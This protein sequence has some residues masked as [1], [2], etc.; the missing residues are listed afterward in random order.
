MNPL[1]GVVIEEGQTLEL[2]VS[3]KGEPAPEVT[4]LRNDEPI[5][6]S[7]GIKTSCDD[8][9]NSS[10]VISNATA[11]DEA[12]FTCKIQNDFG[13]ASSACEVIIKD[14]TIAPEFVEKLQAVQV[15]EDKRA[16]FKVKIEG[17]PE[18]EVVWYKD[19]KMIESDER[20]SILKLKDGFHS[21][22]ID[23]CRAT[24]KSRIKC[25][26][27]NRAGK[28][29]CWAD[30]LV[31]QTIGPPRVEPLTE[32]DIDFIEGSDVVFEAKVTGKPKA[33]VEWIR[34]GKPIVWS[35]RKY[36]LSSDADEHKLIIKKPTERDTGEY[37]CVASSSAGKTTKVFTIKIKGM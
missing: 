31:K 33:K 10:L 16:E 2:N 36:G 12:R 11:E 15:V 23:N 17:V 7:S 29:S 4:W 30:L 24:D 9:F 37:K 27:T 13:E 21:L 1:T 25:I 26:A 8:D 35:T 5:E 22:A 3:F 32:T 28:T 18:P 20:H 34:A 19:D 14:I 6:E